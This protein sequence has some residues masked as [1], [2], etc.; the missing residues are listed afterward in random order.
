[1]V[2]VTGL[3]SRQVV[4]QYQAGTALLVNC[5]KWPQ[6]GRDPKAAPAAADLQR[7]AGRAPAFIRCVAAGLGVA[8]ERGREPIGAALA[9]GHDIC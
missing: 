3:F 4:C 9:R 6:I 2:P 8:K 1:M 5:K 7:L